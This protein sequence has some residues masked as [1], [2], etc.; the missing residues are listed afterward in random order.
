MKD[1]LLIELRTEELPP[2]SL[3]ALSEAF[4]DT[5]FSALQAQQFTSVESTCTPYAT[6]RR[7]ALIVTEVAE[8]QPDRLLEKKGPAVAGAV[9]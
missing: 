8:R 3:K 2:K 4:A 1:A 6:P 9:D 7:L 5:V